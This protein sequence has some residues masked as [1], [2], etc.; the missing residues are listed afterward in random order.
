ME[1]PTSRRLNR[2]ERQ[3]LRAAI[4]HAVRARLGTPRRACPECGA[5]LT[6]LP[7]PVHGCTTCANRYSLRRRRAERS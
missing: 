7:A 1:T 3:A 2:T 5:N 4:D 6:D